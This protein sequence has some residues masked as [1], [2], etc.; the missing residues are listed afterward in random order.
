MLRWGMYC[1]GVI[2]HA[3][4]YLRLGCVSF[5]R[6]VILMGGPSVDETEFDSTYD[7]S[8]T[9]NLTN[10][11]LHCSLISAD[12]YFHCFSDP[13]IIENR[14]K[15]EIF[16]KILLFS[17]KNRNYRA[18]IPIQYIQYVGMWGDYFRAR[19]LVYNQYSVWVDKQKFCLSRFAFPNMKTIF[20]DCA[21]PWAL[22]L[23][24]KNVFV[25]GFDANYGQGANKS[26]ASVSSGYVEK[27]VASGNSWGHDVIKNADMYLQLVQSWSDCEIA[28]AKNSGYAKYR[29]SNGN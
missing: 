23:G 7:C 29:G 12:A 27:N 21:L 5:E 6:V 2:F 3:L 22:Y 4:S 18:I 28:F 8:I 11:E 24:A 17:A 20:L 9:S 10:P 14:D 19:V 15:R 13:S 25:A 1:A 16:R 26:Y